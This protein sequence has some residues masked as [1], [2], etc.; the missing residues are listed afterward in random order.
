MPLPVE[1][2]A[3]H[4]ARVHSMRA[5]PMAFLLA[6]CNAPPP[7]D[8]WQIVWQDEFA[9]DGAPDPTRWDYEYGK[10]RNGEAQFYTR[11]RQANARVEGGVLVLEARREDHE[12]SAFTSA[13]LHTKGKATFR[14][15]RVEVRAKLPRGRGLWPAIWMLG[16]E[17]PDTRWPDCGEIDVMEF[18]GH[19]PAVVHHNVHT[20]LRNHIR[21]NGLGTQVS[22]ADASEAFHVY[23]V[24]WDAERLEFAI[25]GVVRY[26]VENDH[27]G[28]ASWPFDA[29]FFLLLNVAVGGSWGGQQGI[30]ETVFPQRME[31][32]WVRVAVA[33]RQP[34]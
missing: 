21:G 15:A 25:D 32:D 9:I 14:H 30:D 23:G 16:A 8:G 17:W 31:I 6:A 34:G 26:V 18:V 29:P 2:R 22:L 27:Q 13:S 10:V 3:G 19:Q 12:G 1:A 5:V 33:R 7:A 28:P 20:A 4:A 11:Q 24:T